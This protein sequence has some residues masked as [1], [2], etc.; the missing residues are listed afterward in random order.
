VQLP[1][2][3]AIPFILRRLLATVVFEIALH[4]NLLFSRS[5]EGGAFTSLSIGFMPDLL[6][7]KYC[8]ANEVL[9]LKK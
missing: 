7:Q 1:E 5:T 4:L 6:Q 9:D 8:V 3:V 2:D